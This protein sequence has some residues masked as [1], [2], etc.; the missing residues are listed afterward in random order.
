MHACILQIFKILCVS[1]R[2][3]SKGIQM[4]EHL[5][6]IWLSLPLDFCQAVVMDEGSIGHGGEGEKFKW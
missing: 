2:F 1:F 3:R 6:L 4:C 5:A